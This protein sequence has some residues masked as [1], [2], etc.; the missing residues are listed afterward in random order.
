MRCSAKLKNGN[1]CRNPAKFGD[2]CGLHN[3]VK[4]RETQKVEENRKKASLSSTPTGKK[5]LTNLEK[6]EK[7]IDKKHKKIIKDMKKELEKPTRRKTH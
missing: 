2:V 7:T 4:K 6:L 5:L 1:P 3:N